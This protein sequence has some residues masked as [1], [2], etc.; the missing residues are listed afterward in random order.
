MKSF[1]ATADTTCSG[2]SG[3]LPVNTVNSTT[4]AI[5]GTSLENPPGPSTSAL[6]S[7][8]VCVKRTCTSALVSVTSPTMM[9]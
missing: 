8:S 6:T 5:P 3:S 4:P 7:P 1:P 9:P 2:P